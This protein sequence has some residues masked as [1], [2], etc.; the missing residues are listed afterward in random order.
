M[1]I[2]QLACRVLAYVPTAGVRPFRDDVARRPTV[3]AVTREPGLSNQLA[4]L[5]HNAGRDVV[6]LLVPAYERRFDRF[7]VQHGRR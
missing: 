7:R 4:D 3:R 1:R 6:T 2:R 5:N